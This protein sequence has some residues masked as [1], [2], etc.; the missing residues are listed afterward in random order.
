MSMA[1]LDAHWSRFLRLPL[2]RN[3]VAAAIAIVTSGSEDSHYRQGLG[4]TAPRK[5]A[6]Y[7]R[8]AVEGR[9]GLPIDEG[10]ELESRSL[11]ID[12]T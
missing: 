9:W 4:A 3:F 1:G 10:R 11:V 2:S 8:R 12:R 6:D 7:L 5:G